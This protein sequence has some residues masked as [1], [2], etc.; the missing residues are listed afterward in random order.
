MFAET[1]TSGLLGMGN[2]FWMVYGIFQWSI[3][4]QSCGSVGMSLW[5]LI[6]RHWGYWMNTKTV[7]WF[8]CIYKQGTIM[9]RIYASERWKSYALC[10]KEERLFAHSL[11]YTATNREL[12]NVFTHR[13]HCECNK[14]IQ[15]RYHRDYADF[16]TNRSEPE[17][18]LL[19]FRSSP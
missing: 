14:V 15:F 9:Y 7:S 4:H 2:M 6:A 16:V 12:W 13:R 11:F 19:N 17:I 18:N 8:D 3:L 5:W 10:P 1:K